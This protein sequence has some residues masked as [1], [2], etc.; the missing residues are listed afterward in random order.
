MGTLIFFFQVIIILTLTVFCTLLLL[1]Y[2]YNTYLQVLQVKARK[3]KKNS[4]QEKN[5]KRKTET[6]LLRFIYFI[7]INCNMT[8]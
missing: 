1:L 6:C 5:S 4:V 8:T 3:L 7:K 2:S